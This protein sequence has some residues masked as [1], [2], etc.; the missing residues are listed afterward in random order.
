VLPQ[1]DPRPRC[2]PKPNRHQLMAAIESTYDSRP[3]DISYSDWI[4]PAEWAVSD[5]ESSSSHDSHTVKAQARQPKQLVLN[6]KLKPFGNLQ[7]KGKRMERPVSKQLPALPPCAVAFSSK[8][9]GI[10]NRPDPRDRRPPGVR[11]IAAEG[12]FWVN[13]S[14]DIGRRI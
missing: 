10:V 8:V 3:S 9:G 13:R 5:N 7:G 6:D 14:E 4:P 12:G 2:C 1:A 11:D